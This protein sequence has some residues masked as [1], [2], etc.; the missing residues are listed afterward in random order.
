MSNLITTQSVNAF[1]KGRVFKKAN[2][3]VEVRPFKSER[4]DSAILKLHGNVIA[5]RS[6][7]GDVFEICDGG[8]QSRTTKAR[9]NG[10][11][12]VSVVQRKGVWF[13]NGTEWHGHW[14][15]I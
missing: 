7:D 3:A 2:M 1:M 13:L 5:R 4:R 11:P 8:W 14:T 9:L 15:T 12:G 6:L 10:I